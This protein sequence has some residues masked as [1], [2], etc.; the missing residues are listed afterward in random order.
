MIR[1]KLLQPAKIGGVQK[2]PGAVIELDDAS[3][4]ELVTLGLAER[5]DEPA[6]D[7]DED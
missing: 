4:L 7:S 1:I 6:P 3:G 2:A 5:I